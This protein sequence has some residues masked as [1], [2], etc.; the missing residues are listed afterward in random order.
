M[1]NHIFIINFLVAVVTHIKFI[2]STIKT[3]LQYLW[4]V[5]LSLL[6]VGLTNTKQVIFLKPNLNCFPKSNKF[7]ISTSKILFI[8][9]NI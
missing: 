4:V 7:S 5:L 2:S 3:I 8:V 6:C 9:P 1:F